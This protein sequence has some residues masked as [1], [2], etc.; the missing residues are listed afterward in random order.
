M[1]WKGHKLWRSMTICKAG[2]ETNWTGFGGDMAQ[3]ILFNCPN[4]NALYQVVKS[5]PGPET[6]VRAVTCRPCGA[7]LPPR[8]G[9]FANKYFFLRNAGRTQRWTRT[10]RG[11]A[12]RWTSRNC[13]KISSSDWELTMSDRQY[14]EPVAS[15]RRQLAVCGAFLTSAFCYAANSSVIHRPCKSFC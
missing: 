2:G 9:K 12:Q 14:G 11:S 3:R 15:R 6:V 7:P 8:E 5:E 1:S 4:C 13:R 10:K